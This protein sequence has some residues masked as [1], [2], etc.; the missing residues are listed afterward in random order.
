M[1]HTWHLKSH[2]TWWAEARC[3]LVPGHPGRDGR[4][5]GKV[6]GEQEPL[7]GG[8]EEDGRRELVCRGSS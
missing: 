6:V 3:H 7:Q 4:S 2:E 1:A 8:E 5:A